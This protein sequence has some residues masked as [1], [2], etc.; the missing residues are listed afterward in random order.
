[1]L[2]SMCRGEGRKQPAAQI[3]AMRAFVRVKTLGRPSSKSVR[4]PDE[5]ANVVMLATTP[6]A[7]QYLPCRDTFP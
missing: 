2:F 1:M 6:F 5:G 3:G 7:W 4:D